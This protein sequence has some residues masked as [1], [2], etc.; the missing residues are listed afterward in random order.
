VEAGLP[1]VARSTQYQAREPSDMGVDLHHQTT[2]RDSIARKPLP[3]GM[4]RNAPF[5][6]KVKRGAL[7]LGGPRTPRLAPV[8]YASTRLSGG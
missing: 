2:L 6:S 4:G 8:K 7:L 1:L 5:V 3:S